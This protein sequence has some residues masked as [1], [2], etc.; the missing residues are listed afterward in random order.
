MG[1]AVKNA[2]VE[3]QHHEYERVEADPEPELVHV[4]F[5]RKSR[6]RADERT[7]GEPPRASRALTMPG[8]Y[9]GLAQ[10]ATSAI[11]N[12]CDLSDRA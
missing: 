6:P 3:R 10:S 4:P 2:K 7:K 9:E 8:P 11:G 1:L 5:L 12:V